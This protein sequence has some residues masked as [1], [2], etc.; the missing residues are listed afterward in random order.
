MRATF[1]TYIPALGGVPYRVAPT[2]LNPGGSAKFQIEPSTG[3]IAR[4]VLTRSC[5]VGVFPGIATA[6][7]PR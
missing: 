1:G 7:K 4:P 3:E 2:S 6:S 5:D